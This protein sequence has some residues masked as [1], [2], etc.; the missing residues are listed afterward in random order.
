MAWLN[1]WHEA[2][3]ETVFL[4]PRPM[5]VHINSIVRT[6]ADMVDL[7]HHFF[8]HSADTFSAM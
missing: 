8:S 6:L 3:T 4:W 7:M 1:D 5:D 2:E